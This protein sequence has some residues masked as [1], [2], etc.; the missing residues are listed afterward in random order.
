M[1]VI[2]GINGERDREIELKRV[3][4]HARLDV[5]NAQSNC[6]IQLMCSSVY[7]TRAI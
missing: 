5:Q 4:D 1:A 7:V 2:D 3:I 6:I